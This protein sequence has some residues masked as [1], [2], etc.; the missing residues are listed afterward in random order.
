MKLRAYAVAL[1]FATG[2]GKM[3][4]Q[5]YF[6]RHKEIMESRATAQFEKMNDICK[7]NEE[8][9]FNQN[10]RKSTLPFREIP[11]EMNIDGLNSLAAMH[12]DGTT[13]VLRYTSY[14][15]NEPLHIDMVIRG[16]PDCNAETKNTKNE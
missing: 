3:V 14:D 2:L 5:H 1:V 11:Y 7:T 9:V 8:I 16:V 13:A 6:D 4:G 10:R 12:V 15:F